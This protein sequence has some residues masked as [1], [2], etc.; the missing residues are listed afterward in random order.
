MNIEI[1]RNTL[2][3]AY[4]E[5]FYAYSM[6]LG[7]ITGEIM[8][9]LLQFEADRRSINITI[10]SFGTELSK[11]DRQKLYPEIGKLQPFGIQKL[12]KADD[13]DQV[14]QAVDYILEYRKLFSELGVGGSKTLEDAFFAHEVELNKASFEQQFHYGVFYSYI[15]L[16]EQEIRN[17]LWCS[18]CIAQSQRD[19]IHNYIPIF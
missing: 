6:K 2:Y 15:K 19:K 17:L 9:E 13:Q 11:D 8:G 18:E 7:G 16:K 3:K 14:R 4:I 10:N 5:D 12:S 1:I